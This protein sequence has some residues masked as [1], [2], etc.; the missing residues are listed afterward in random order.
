MSL[1]STFESVYHYYFQVEEKK[2]RKV[3][4]VPPSTHYQNQTLRVQKIYMLNQFT[5]EFVNQGKNQVRT[6]IVE[7]KRSWMK[8]NPAFNI[9]KE[10]TF[11]ITKG[12]N[13]LLT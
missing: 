5:Q 11:T 9:T 12:I 7:S 8:D 10:V 13:V 6:N 4:S 2:E 3:N 1:S